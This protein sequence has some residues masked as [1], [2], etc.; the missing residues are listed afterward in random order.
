VFKLINQVP[1]SYL[2]AKSCFCYQKDG[3]EIISANSDVTVFH[4]YVNIHVLH[5][6][7]MAVFSIC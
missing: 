4:K 2:V 1:E 5:L 3:N 7:Y 6:C